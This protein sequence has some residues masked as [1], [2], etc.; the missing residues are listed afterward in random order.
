MIHEQ[1][2]LDETIAFLNEV[3]A[4]DP[5][6]VTRLVETRVSCTE[7]LADHPS[8]QVQDHKTGTPSVGLLGLLNG[9]FG[10]DEENWGAIAAL[11][12][13]DGRLVR[14]ER[15]SIEIRAARKAGTRT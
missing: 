4:L 7:A 11:F 13:D 10:A 1:R 2:T 5:A 3:L 15:S 8:V 14:F 12:E 6:A 9:L